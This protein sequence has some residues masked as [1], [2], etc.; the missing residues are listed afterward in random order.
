M[1]EIASRGRRLPTAVGMT[2]DTTENRRIV[3]ARGAM[4]LL[5]LLLLV[6]GTVVVRLRSG[7][8]QQMAQPTAQ[9]RSSASQPS[10]LVKEEEAM[11][12][13]PTQASDSG[14]HQGVAADIQVNGRSIPLPQNGQTVHQETVENNGSKTTVDVQFDSSTTSTSAQSRSTLNLN[15]QSSQVSETQEE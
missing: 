7:E 12:V 8:A 15:V 2:F 11:I 9:S 14:A 6:A 4:M 13:E 3:W 1:P 10:A 5:I